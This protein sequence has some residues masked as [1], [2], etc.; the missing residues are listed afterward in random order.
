VLFLVF[1]DITDEYDLLQLEEILKAK[2]DLFNQVETPV[3][4]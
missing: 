3:I 4:L 2:L 1:L